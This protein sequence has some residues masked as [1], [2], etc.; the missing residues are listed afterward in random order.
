MPN[1]LSASPSIVDHRAE[2][3]MGLVILNGLS[4]F[5]CCAAY[6]SQFS[7]RTTTWL[8]WHIV[9]QYRFARKI[10]IDNSYAEWLL[11]RQKQ[12]AVA[13]EESAALKSTGLRPATEQ[14]GY[15]LREACIS[16]SALILVNYFWWRSR[17]DEKRVLAW[18]SHDPLTFVVDCTCLFLI[19]NEH[20][21]SVHACVCSKFFFCNV[22]YFLA[23]SFP[24]IASE[25]HML[26]CIIAFVST[27]VKALIW[28][29][30]YY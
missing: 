17:N 29:W 1:S 11:L 30:Q 15:R 28:C 3:E 26:S 25:H 6:C 13:A 22:L 9:G 8:E 4:I 2:A 19:F 18:H 16:D 20:Y 14:T 27:S 24:L 23:F 10:A 7:R 21:A 12:V 5:C